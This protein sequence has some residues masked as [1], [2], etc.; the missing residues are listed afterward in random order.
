MSTS[1]EKLR[2][3]EENVIRSVLDLTERT[4]GEETRF[5]RKSWVWVTSAQMRKRIT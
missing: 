1:Q 2:R 4:I 5:I 3:E